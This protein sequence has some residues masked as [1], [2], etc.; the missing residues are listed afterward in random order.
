MS[1]ETPTE[2]TCV[3]SN[4]SLQS[5]PPVPPSPGLSGVEQRGDGLDLMVDR[6]HP[7]LPSLL[8]PDDAIPIGQYGISMQQ[9]SITFFCITQNLND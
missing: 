7:H 6:T 4:Q 3:D 2:G 9:V 1:A 5:P 8:S